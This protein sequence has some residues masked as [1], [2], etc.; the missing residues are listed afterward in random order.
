MNLFSLLLLIILYFLK[1]SYAFQSLRSHRPA[2][3]FNKLHQTPPKNNDNSPDNSNTDTG[4]DTQIVLGRAQELTT[5][6]T[7]T[8][9]KTFNLFRKG[10]SQGGF[11]QAVATTLA[12]DYNEDKVKAIILEELKSAPC[13]GECV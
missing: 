11:K 9:T 2:I 13:V 5:T 8:L 12:G 7:E 3:N 4:I 6:T 10:L 1:V